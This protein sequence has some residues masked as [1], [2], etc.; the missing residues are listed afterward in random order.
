ME[1]C[2]ISQDFQQAS[3][4]VMCKD[5]LADAFWANLY[6]KTTEIYDFEYDSSKWAKIDMTCC[7]LGVANQSDA[8]FYEH[9]TGALDFINQIAK[10]LRLK[11]SQVI[12]CSNPPDR[13]KSGVFVFENSAMWL[14]SPPLLSLLS[15]VIRIGMIHKK[16]N[17]STDTFRN[18]LSSKIHYGRDD[19]IQLKEA[20]QGINLLLSLGYRKHF[21]KDNRKNWPAKADVEDIHEH[22]GIVGFSN[23]DSESIV[24]K[25]HRFKKGKK[26]I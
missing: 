15:L 5:F 4:F 14:N 16:G 26:V 25:W 23:G 1:Y 2:W 21:Y 3:R 13:Y 9:I 17:R 7:R 18:V 20:R 8:K 22:C 19:T 24:P 10:M 12:R 6:G 11:T